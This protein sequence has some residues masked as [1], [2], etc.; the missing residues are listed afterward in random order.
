MRLTSWS[1]LGIA[2]GLVGLVFPYAMAAEQASRPL[3]SAQLVAVEGAASTYHLIDYDGRVVTAVVPS[4]STTDIQH[5]SDNT[6]HATLASVDSATNRVKVVTREG[7]TLV[8]TLA[9][10][11]LQGLQIGDPVEFVLPAPNRDKSASLRGQ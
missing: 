7:Q 8:L 9:P 2:L 11:A 5:S 6:V 3:P 1:I 10:Q 4:Q